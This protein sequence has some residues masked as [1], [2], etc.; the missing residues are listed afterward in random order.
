M[1]SMEI[2]VRAQQEI[3]VIKLRGKLG[4]GDPVDKLRG[5]IDDLMGR[6]DV[7]FILDL[8][9]VPMVDSSGIGLLVRLLTSLKQRG[10]YLK[11]LSPS[12]M[13]HQTLKMIGLINQFEIFDEQTK[14]I[15]SFG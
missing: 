5:T 3:Q 10:G 2:E 6:G 12:K 4:L 11:L 13:T 1:V 9:E 8:A 15:D 7:N 14:A